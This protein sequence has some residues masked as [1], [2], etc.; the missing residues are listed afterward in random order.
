MK[1]SFT[2]TQE[3]MTQFQKTELR[4]TEFFQKHKVVSI[5]LLISVLLSVAAFSVFGVETTIDLS[6]YYHHAFPFFLWTLGVDVLWVLL[7]WVVVQ[8]F[9]EF[10]MIVFL[11]WLGK[12]ITAFYIIQW[13]II[14]NIVTAI[15]QTQKLSSYAYWFGAIFLVTVGLTWLFEKMKMKYHRIH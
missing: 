1:I 5:L 4:I 3:G 9:S 15:Y 10:P 2:G 6:K 12:N 8:R 11:R 14:G 7:L 13:L